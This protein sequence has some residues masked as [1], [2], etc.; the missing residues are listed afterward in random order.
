M[1]PET[2][3]IAGG[4]FNALIAVFHLAFWKLFRWRDEVARMSRVNGAILQV[5]NLRLT[6]FF[7]LFAALAFI[8]PAELVNTAMGK[9]LLG[10]MAIFWLMRAVEQVIFFGLSQPASKIFFASCF[11]GVAANAFP[12]LA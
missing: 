5:M 4:I 2:A 7:I 12:A 8:F 9:T 6:W 3:V 1:T 10:A 11:I